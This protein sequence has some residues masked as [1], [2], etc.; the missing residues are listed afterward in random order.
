[1]EGH[2]PHADDK[3]VATVVTDHAV[4]R[5]TAESG[6]VCANSQGGMLREGQVCHAEAGTQLQE[7]LAARVAVDAELARQD[8]MAAASDARLEACERW[9]DE[10]A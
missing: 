7:V 6:H 8:A 4:C 9:E 2:G 3:P 5:Y 1:M 10:V